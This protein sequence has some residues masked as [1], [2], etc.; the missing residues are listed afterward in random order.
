MSNYQIRIEEVQTADFRSQSYSRDNCLGTDEN[1]LNLENYIEGPLR[2]IEAARKALYSPSLNARKRASFDRAGS[3]AS[4]MRKYSEQSPGGKPGR[5]CLSRAQMS[6]PYELSQDL[7]DKQME[8]LSNKYGGSNTANS[9][10]NTIQRAYRRYTM[11]KKFKAITSN[12]LSRRFASMSGG[13]GAQDGGRMQDAANDSTDG[14]Q[15][16]FHHDCCVYSSTAKSSYAGLTKVSQYNQSETRVSTSSTKCSIE[17]F[18]HQH[19]FDNSHRL[20]SCALNHSHISSTPPPGGGQHHDCHTHS[21][22]T[23]HWGAHTPHNHI[24]VR[25]GLSLE[26]EESSDAD[27]QSFPVDYLPDRA[28]LACMNRALVQRQLSAGRVIGPSH[29]HCANCGSGQ[30]LPSHHSHRVS[31]SRKRAPDVPKRTVSRL[32]SLDVGES[33]ELYPARS[34]EPHSRSSSTQSS[35]RIGGLDV[36]QSKLEPKQFSAH[37]SPNPPSDSRNTPRDLNRNF[38]SAADRNLDQ[39]GQDGI[40]SRSKDGY[41]G[42]YAV[43]EVIR[44]RHYRTG[45]NIFNKKPE[46]GIN[47]LINK[48]FLDNSPAAVAR[49]LVTRKGLSKQ[50]IGEY[51]GNISHPFNQAVLT[52]FAAEVD[53]S[54]TQVDSALRKFQTYFRMPGEAQKIERLM[55]VFSQRYCTCNPN[56]ASKLHSPDTIFILAFA[57]ILLNT[58]LHTPSLKPEKRMKAEDFIK[59]LRGIDGGADV[60]PV[61][62]KSAKR[63][64]RCISLAFCAK[65]YAKVYDTV[66][67]ELLYTSYATLGQHQREVFLFNDILVITKIHSRRKNSV[68]YTFRNSFPLTG[69]VVSLFENSYY[70]HGIILTQRWDKKIV[71]TLNARNDHDRSKFVEDL[72]ESVAEM[73]EMEALRIEG[74]LEKQHVAA[75]VSVSSDFRDSGITDLDPHGTPARSGFGSV[76]SNVNLKR[77]AINNS[78]LDLTDNYNI[79][80]GFTQQEKPTR[81][82]SVGSLDSGM[83]VSFQSGSAGSAGTV[84]QE[85]SPQQQLTVKT[86]GVMSHHLAAPRPRNLSANLSTNL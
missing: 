36:L 10:A 49:F 58:D 51:L 77:G 12:R 59:N 79:H 25:P 3:S 11:D 31:G 14:T 26:D 13:G 67:R 66:C 48:G 32:T 72:R 45:L 81:R 40:P 5:K 65:A 24:G 18:R 50:M 27:M 17:E 57:I 70:S 28:A 63:K 62:F 44:K 20:P 39:S 41:P 69:M 22:P 85:S 68:T 37:P 75:R 55:E 43:N 80:P 52:C 47:Y 54:G 7:L 76:E 30:A 82:G 1:H 9:A 33:G 53:L 73:D 71:I 2:Q 38:R 86:S 8:V 61:G 64:K 78:L 42:N 29:A 6:E 84:S 16:N 23:R 60:D 21:C 34:S 74:E 4:D 35:P 56:I 46:K 15:Q 83:S 19:Q